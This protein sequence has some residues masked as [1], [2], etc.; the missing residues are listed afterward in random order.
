MGAH[1]IEM[2]E[3]ASPSL[4]CVRKRMQAFVSLTALEFCALCRARPIIAGLD[5]LPKKLYKTT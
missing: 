4:R 2:G 3:L 5:A 1:T